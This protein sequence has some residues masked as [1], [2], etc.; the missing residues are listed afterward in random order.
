MAVVAEIKDI[1]VCQIIKN[2]NSLLLIKADGGVNKDKWNAPNGDIQK[3]EAPAKAAIRVA[4]Q[5][6]GLY[7]T[8]VRSHG[9]IR[10]FLNG[11]NEY[12][13]RLLIFSTRLF[14]GDLKPNIKGEARWFDYSDIPYYEMWADDKYWINLVQQEKEF[15][16]DFFFDEKN[17]TIVKYQIKERKKIFQKVI[18]PALIIALIAGVAA[19]SVMSMHLFSHAN[20][21]TT[22]KQ[23][24]LKQSHN[25]TTTASST[26]TIQATLTTTIPPA[27]A[28]TTIDNIDL[29][30]NYTGPSSVAGQDC[31]VPKSSHVQYVQRAFAGGTQFLWNTTIYSGGCDLTISGIYTTTPG[32]K[33]KSVLPSTPE[34]I[35]A[36]SQ[37]YYEVEF[38][39]PSTTYTGPLSIVINLS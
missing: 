28:L 11:K 19:F 36:D 24:V 39:T 22:S 35:G 31:R 34:T 21:T 3:G 15:D 20:A 12:T 25:T 30:Y 10:L 4:F 16:A 2:G 8:K 26:T 32:F 29:T 14:S 38:V 27:P 6:T 9:I 18:V 37:I 13:Y 33:V 17:E 7:V 5:Q 23:V 1:V